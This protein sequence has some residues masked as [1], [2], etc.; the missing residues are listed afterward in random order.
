[1]GNRLGHCLSSI[2]DFGHGEHEGVG[3]G[4]F[5]VDPGPTIATGV[6]EISRKSIENLANLSKLCK[7]LLWSNKGA[8]R[9]I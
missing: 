1:M 6:V 7:S 4:C 9:S 2:A 5:S 3:L 8:S